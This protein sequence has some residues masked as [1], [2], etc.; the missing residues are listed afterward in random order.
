MI[1]WYGHALGQ[2]PLPFCRSSL[3]IISL[4]SLSDVVSLKIWSN[5]ISYQCFVQIRKHIPRNVMLKCN[6][7]VYFV[8]MRQQGRFAGFSLFVSKTGSIENSSL[9][10]KDGPILPS[11][12]LTIFC[13]SNGRYII[14]YNER[15]LEV[16]Y[17][18]EYDVSFALTELCEVNVY[19]NL[20]SKYSPIQFI[21]VFFRKVTN[22]CEG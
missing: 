15:L 5:K 14:F 21:N 3:V 7:A 6:S 1:Y 19:G 16:S 4:Y 9:C 12:N 17:S 13:N 18:V 22:K 11:L 2:E 10:Y 20:Y 8:E